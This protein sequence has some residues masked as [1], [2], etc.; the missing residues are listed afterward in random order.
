[1]QLARELSRAPMIRLIALDIDGTLVGADSLVSAGNVAA[2]RAARHAGCNIVLVTG[3]S[4]TSSMPI[5]EQF[6][7]GVI[8]GLGAFD[9]AYAEV[10]PDGPVLVDGRIATSAASD[11]VRVMSSYGLGAVVFPG[12]R[13]DGT[14]SASAECPPGEKWLSENRHRTRLLGL[15]DLQ[16][17]LEKGPITL[18]A[19]GEE[20]VVQACAAELRSVLDGRASVSVTYSPRYDGHFAQVAP[21]GLDKGSAVRAFAR[22]FGIPR[23]ETAAIGDW[24]ND[25]SMLECAGVRVVMEG[26]PDELGRIADMVTKPAELDGVAAAVRALCNL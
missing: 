7:E 23:E 18:S 4:R 8:G 2:L 13:S 6:P 12:G 19:Y 5:V 24:L 14:V 25:L 22:Y 26:C 3:R 20:A 15:H 17:E 21:N 1:M 10:L 16:R 11:A 9:G